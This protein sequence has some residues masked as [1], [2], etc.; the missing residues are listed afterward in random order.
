LNIDA[1]DKLIESL[2]KKYNYE[3]SLQIP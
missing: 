1:I 2:L 3:I